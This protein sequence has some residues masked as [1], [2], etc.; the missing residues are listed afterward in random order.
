M[1]RESCPWPE[2]VDVD[3][4]SRSDWGRPSSRCLFAVL[5]VNALVS[6]EYYPCRV[7]AA[8]CCC[9]F[10]VFFRSKQRPAVRLWTMN[11]KKSKAAL[12]ILV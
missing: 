10:A 6:V 7:K 8:H 2:S 1:L 9:A 3:S 11:S 5:S 12:F 4:G